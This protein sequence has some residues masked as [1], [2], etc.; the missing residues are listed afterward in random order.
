[1]NGIDLKVTE[2]SINQFHCYYSGSTVVDVEATPSFFSSI[3]R[4][5]DNFTLMT[6]KNLYS[7]IVGGCMPFCDKEG[8][9]GRNMP[10][11]SKNKVL[12]V[13]L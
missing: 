5:C 11:F 8:G 4:V 13:T 9:D 7:N 10:G 12:N 1:V 3:A 6:R 2:I